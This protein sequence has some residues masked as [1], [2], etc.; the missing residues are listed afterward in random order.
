MTTV[1]IALANIPFPT[2]PLDSVA[3]ALNAVAQAGAER[4]EIVCFPEGYIPG[5]R[6]KSVPAPPPD[7]AF[8]EDAWARVAAAA[9]EARVVVVLGTERVTAAGLLM[10][11][12]VIDR[13]GKRLGFQ[14]KVQLDPSEDGLYTPG[15]G[16][17]VF[18]VGALTFGIAI[19]HEG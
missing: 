8:L 19:C 14:D 4:A 16:R 3:R 15:A 18:T 1:R 12:L 6:Q 10:S 17:R 5:Y 2:N 7:S 11:T 13:E 9:A